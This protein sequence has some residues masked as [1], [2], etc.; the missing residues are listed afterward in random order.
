MWGSLGISCGGYSLVC[1]SL[2]SSSEKDRQAYRELVEATTAPAAELNSRELDSVTIAQ[3]K[4]TEHSQRHFLLPGHARLAVNLSAQHSILEA[5][6]SRNLLKSSNI[7]KMSK[8]FMQEEL[9]YLLPDGREAF[10]QENGRLLLRHG[11]PLKD[12]DWVDFS[13]TSVKAMQTLRYFEAEH[14]TYHYKDNHL[15]TQQMNVVRY[16][17]PG[18]DPV[19][20]VEGFK[21]VFT[22]VAESAEIALADTQFKARQLKATY[23]QAEPVEFEAREAA[24]DSKSIAMSGNVFLEHA[25]GTLSANQAVLTGVSE[26]RKISLHHLDL[27]DHVKLHLSKVAN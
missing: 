2:F 8:G 13:L 3:Q 25:L 9:Y 27:Y 7:S 1:F 22:G 26:G 20:N 16:V 19:S 18:H 14:A 12:Q 5:R 23:F 4:R 15:L 10:L 6:P 24:Y 21:P 17:I 11:D